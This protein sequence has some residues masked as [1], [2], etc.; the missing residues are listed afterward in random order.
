MMRNY[1]PG[2]YNTDLDTPDVDDPKL[3]SSPLGDAVRFQWEPGDFTRYE[4]V[5]VHPGD[6]NKYAYLAWVNRHTPVVL[7]LPTFWENGVHF[8]YIQSKLGVSEYDAQ[9]VSEFLKLIGE[10]N[11]E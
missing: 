4:F 7:T 1:P 9:K 8:T 6:K 3:T 5:L 2:A 11:H 10:G